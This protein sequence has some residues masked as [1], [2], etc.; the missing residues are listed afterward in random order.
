[1]YVTLSINRIGGWLCF[2]GCLSRRT[3]SRSSWTGSMLNTYFST[4]SVTA[5][6]T[7]TPMANAATETNDFATTWRVAVRVDRVS[8]CWPEKSD[9]HRHSYANS[10]NGRHTP[11]LRQVTLR[12]TLIMLSQFVPSHPDAH[13]HEKFPCN[14]VVQRARM[15]QNDV[16]LFRS[17][18]TWRGTLPPCRQVV[19]LQ[20]RRSSSQL[21]PLKPWAQRHAYVGAMSHGRLEILQ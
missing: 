14:N 19:G 4:S 5:K 3:C 6:P 10:G 16:N 12:H 20:G 17:S 13:A 21:V 2:T 8:Q 15:I 7:T 9:T 18:E 1:M 11:W